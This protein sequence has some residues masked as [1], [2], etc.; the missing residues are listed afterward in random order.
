MFFFMKS[1][2]QCLVT[3]FAHPK[4]TKFHEKSMVN[5][6]LRLSQFVCYFYADQIQSY[7]FSAPEYINVEDKEF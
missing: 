1:H 6:S 3:N 7:F 4:L 2:I 5:S